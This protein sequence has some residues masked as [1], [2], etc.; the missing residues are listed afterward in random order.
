MVS[1]LPGG[2]DDRTALLLRESPLVESGRVAGACDLAVVDDQ[3]LW[4]YLLSLEVGFE[5][6]TDA[7]GVASLR[8]QRRAGDVRRHGVVGQRPPRM[9]GRRGLDVPR[10]AGVPGQVAG[11]QRLD[12]GVAIDDRPAGRVDQPG[13]LLHVEQ[14]LAV[15]QTVRIRRQWNVDGDDVGPLDEIVEICPANAED[16]LVDAADGRK[17]IVEHVDV[18]ALEAHGHLLPDPTHTDDPNGLVF[19]V[20]GLRGDLTDAP[21]AFDHVLIGRYEVAPQGQDLHDGVLGDAGDVAAA[22]L[23]DGD[24]PV[25]RLRQVEVV[26]A[27][28]GQDA[29]TK[30]RRVVEYLLR[31]VD[32]PEGGGDQDLR[33]LEV[34]VE[35]V[36]FPGRRRDQFVPLILDP[37]PQAQRL[38]RAAYQLRRRLLSDLFIRTWVKNHDDLHAYLFPTFLP[39]MPPSTLQLP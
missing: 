27:D 23:G 31:S 7:L 12:E 2:F 3:V 6:V 9:I 1:R 4:P 39:T 18:E 34:V 17:V 28:A 32:G 15:E 29:Q 19:E 30:V 14:P 5:A 20:V 16:V 24:A 25:P 10:V 36:T 33:V 38:V 22:L 11:F 37:L 13:A 35:L 26:G 21:A 8:F